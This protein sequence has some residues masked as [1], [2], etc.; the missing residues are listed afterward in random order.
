[1][2]TFIHHYLPKYVTYTQ[3]L[4]VYTQIFHNKTPHLCSLKCTILKTVKISGSYATVYAFGV[5]KL[6]IIQESWTLV[7]IGQN[8][9]VQYLSQN[10]LT[11]LKLI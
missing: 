10:V 2:I 1:M 3:S 11:I 7:S 5:T 9:W 6:A 8:Y 4:G